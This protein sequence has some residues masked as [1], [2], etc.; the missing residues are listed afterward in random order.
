[1]VSG[2][3]RINIDIIDLNAMVSLVFILALL[4]WHYLYD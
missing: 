2:M 1:M 3:Y 4:V